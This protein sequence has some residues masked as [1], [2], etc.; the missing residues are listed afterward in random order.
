MDYNNPL[1]IA[2]TLAVVAL[3]AV[4]YRLYEYNRSI[5]KCNRIADEAEG[6]SVPEVNLPSCPKGTLKEYLESRCDVTITAMEKL[7]GKGTGWTRVEFTW[8]YHGYVSKHSTVHF[9]TR[10]APLRTVGK[11]LKDI[12]QLNL[13]TSWNY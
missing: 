4:A 6:K 3:L 11:I 13:S 12:E 8:K 1:H 7:T 2:L 9:H 5:K 10:D